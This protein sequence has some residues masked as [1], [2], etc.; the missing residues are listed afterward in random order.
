M[1]RPH[2]TLLLDPK[3]FTFLATTNDQLSIN[4]VPLHSSTYIEYINIVYSLEKQRQNETKK[5][6]ETLSKDI[7]INTIDL[8]ALNSIL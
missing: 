2:Q 8:H 5:N 4:I 6:G 7:I 3:T 1:G